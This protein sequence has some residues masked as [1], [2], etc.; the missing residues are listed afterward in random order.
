MSID[1]PV[2]VEEEREAGDAVQGRRQE[3]LPASLGLKLAL[4]DYMAAHSFTEDGARSHESKNCDWYK[5]AC[6]RIKKDAEGVL[7]I[8]MGSMSP[9]RLE[10]LWKNM[11]QGAMTAHKKA[12]QGNNE[13]K[14]TPEEVSL[15]T[16]T[17]MFVVSGMF[18]LL[19]YRF[20]DSCFVQL[21]SANG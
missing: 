17:R 11:K 13:R 6:E 15:K 12:T 8:E 20:H 7:K 4:I 10:N 3:E 19:R 9:C 5:R 21:T 14:V 16:R 1:H 18:V 2:D